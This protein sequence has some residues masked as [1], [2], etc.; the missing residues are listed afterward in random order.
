M[1]DLT[2]ALSA[3]RSSLQKSKQLRHSRLDISMKRSR[4]SAESECVGSNFWHR[5]EVEG[6]IGGIFTGLSFT[7]PRVIESSVDAHTYKTYHL[8]AIAFTL[9]MS[10]GLIGTIHSALRKQA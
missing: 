8:G 10:I 7:A 4:H 3:S 5:P 9:F 1:P 6:I 2:I